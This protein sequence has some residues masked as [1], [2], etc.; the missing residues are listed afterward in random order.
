[1]VRLGSTNRQAS[2][3]I[4][5]EINLRRMDGSFDA[6]PCYGTSVDDFDSKLVDLMFEH[7]QY[8][9]TS[10]KLQSLGLLLKQGNKIVPSNAGII[11]LGNEEVRFHKFNGARVS[12]A[13]FADTTKA[14]FIDRIDIDGGLL[15]AIEEVPKFIRRNTRMAAEIKTMKRKDIPEYPTAAIREVLINALLHSNYMIQGMRILVAIY[16]DRLDITNPGMLPLGMTMEDFKNGVS[17]I[18]NKAIAQIFKKMDLVETWGSGYERIM[19]FCKKEGY[20]EPTWEEFGSAVRVTF[21]PHPATKLLG[22]KSALSRHQVGTKSAL[23]QEEQN[24]LEFCKKERNLQEMMNLLGWK[25]RTKFR[26]KY[27]IPLLDQGLLAMTIPDKP[28]SSKQ[29]YVAL[30]S[31]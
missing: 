11:L 16:S 13:R 2:P 4:I 5:E 25:D 30:A 26:N 18:R 24:L 29:K 7:F 15:T 12:C 8:K 9:P 23:S 20:P 22:T 6:L 3:Q 1:M 17:T 31:K 21:Y 19:K 27:V 10:A 28:Q 14:E